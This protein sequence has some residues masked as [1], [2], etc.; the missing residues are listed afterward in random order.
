MF[1]IEDAAADGWTSEV[2]VLAPSAGEA[3][4]AL[5]ARGLHKRQIRHQARPV[6]TASAAE[7]PGIEVAPHLLRR[8]DDD[9]GW[10]VWEPAPE[11]ESLNWRASR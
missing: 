4:R 1:V 9:A 2:A 6:R 10:T 3:R 11:H 8:R 7:L 5:A